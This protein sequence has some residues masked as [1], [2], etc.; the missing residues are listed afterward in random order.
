[1]YLLRVILP[2]RPG[3][4]GAV[5]TALGGVGADIEAFEIIE[6][7]TGFAVDDIMVGLPPGVP[8]DRLI[9]AC[10]SLPGV[11]VLFINRFPGAWGLL[12]DMDVLD[13]MVASP[14]EAESILADAAQQVVRAHWAIVVD[15][16]NG[17]VRHATELAPELTAETLPLLGD[18][19][20]LDTRELTE[21][22]LTGWGLT[23]VAIAPFRNRHAIVMARHGGPAF[24]P[25]EL[26]RLRILATITHDS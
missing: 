5:A 15:L 8:A 18:L 9:T 14:V 13:Q 26:T 21:G 3:S 16:D 2:D 12:G 7:R 10:Q 11:E 20:I 17:A 4:L 1:M 19:S 24:L 23:H 22:W 25:S 6:R